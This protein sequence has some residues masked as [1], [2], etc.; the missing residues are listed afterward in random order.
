M[1]HSFLRRQQSGSLLPSSS[2][3]THSATTSASIAAWRFC[4]QFNVVC[5]G[6]RPSIFSIG[7][8]QGL[9][10]AVL[11]IDIR[12]AFHAMVREVVLGGHSLH[13]CLR[14]LLQQ[15]SLDATAV[16]ARAHDPPDLELLG[17]PQCAARLLRDAH[18]HTW[19]TLGATDQIHQTER[20]SRPGSPLAD[21][22]FNGLMALMLKELQQRLD[23]H[24]PLQSA[25]A[26]LGIHALPVAWVD[27]LA[28]PIVAMHATQLVPEI[29]WVLDTV[30]E[31]CSSF[32]L[33]LNLKPKKTEVV[34]T[35]RG[36]GAPDM[37]REWLIDRGGCVPVMS[38]D[39][40]VRCVPR[41]EHLGAIFQPDGHIGDEIKHRLSK[42]HLAYR[43]VRKPIMMNRHLSVRTR[44]TLLDALVVPVM[45]HGA[46]NWPLLSPAQLHQ[47]TATYMKWVAEG[48]VEAIGCKLNIHKAPGIDAVSPVLLKEACT[49]SSIW[50]HQLLFKMWV[51]GTEPLQGK[52]GLLHAIAKKEASCKIADMRGIM[53]IDGLAK[54]A[55]S[56]LRRQ[57]LPTLQRLRH[58][59]QLGSF[60]RSST[61]FATAY[62]RAF[63]QLAK[64]QGL[65][66]A[67]LFIDIRSAFHAMV[68]EVVLG[69]HS[70]HPCLREL[71]QQH[72]L[73]AT[74]VEARAH[75][76]PDLELLGLPQCAARLLRD[77]HCHTWYTLGATDQIHQTERG[78]RPGSPLAD[79]A[80]NGLMALMLKELQQRLDGHV[81][82]QSAF[83]TLGIHAL[84][85]AWLMIWHSPSLPCMPRNWCQKYNGSWILSSRSALRLDSS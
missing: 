14:E 4:P 52:G 77:A 78:S 15:H 25:F 26:T 33:Q 35:F 41:Y 19:Y 43:Q 54:V 9:S 51:L 85:V 62:V 75:D 11:F 82:L 67:V 80:F 65:S 76:P 50:V 7:E 28:L 27:D 39:Q 83:A 34:P 13:P 84:P 47:L 1:V 37:R 31:V 24:V 8:E 66:S 49:R 38:G 44:L 57:L 12:S 70:L 5:H 60:A 21:V 74:A 59:L 61:L 29:Q 18:C 2:A 72:S 20:S 69:G 58:P 71:L 55:H 32:G 53:L 68:R 73:D 30:I 45:L 64:K 3:S 79:V 81:P 48:D 63:S 40:V 17:L 56:F 16:E 22:A 23:G 42:A 10:S 36:D 6:L 46:G